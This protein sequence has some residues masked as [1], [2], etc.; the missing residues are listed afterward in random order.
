MEIIYFNEKN[1]ILSE[2]KTGGVEHDVGSN[3]N[4]LK[5]D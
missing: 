1:K 5:I 2:Y 4:H 3:G